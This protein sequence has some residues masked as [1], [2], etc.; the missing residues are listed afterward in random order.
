MFNISEALRQNKILEVKHMLMETN[1][2]DIA[3]ILENLSRENTLKAFRIL[4]KILPV[5][6]FHIFLQK[7]SK[8]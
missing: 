4:S 6:C 3:S 5:K 1:P 8:R 7:N 2:I